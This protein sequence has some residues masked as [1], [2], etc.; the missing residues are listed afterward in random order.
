M[1]AL[2]WFLVIVLLIVGLAGTFIPVIPGAPIILAAAVIHKIFLPEFLSG[3][4]LAGMAVLAAGATVLDMAATI[5]G[6]KW[7]GATSWGIL[8]SGIGAIVGLFFAVPGILLGAVLGAILGEMIFAKKP[9]KAAAKAGL[10]AGLGLLASVAG[11]A[12][13]C[14]L[15]IAVFVIDCFVS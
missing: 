6:A 14:V 5:G 2:V 10:G 12:A 4:T 7:Y 3:W 13:I 8:G 15:M 9:L 1:E 11:R